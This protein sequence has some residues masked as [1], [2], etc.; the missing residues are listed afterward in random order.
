MRESNCLLCGFKAE[1]LFQHHTHIY[2][3]SL[4]GEYAFESAHLQQVSHLTDFQRVNLLS[5]TSELSSQNRPVFFDFLE[6]NEKFHNFINVNPAEIINE[7]IYHSQKLD[8]LLQEIGRIARNS[9]VGARINLNAKLFAK[10][11]FNGKDEIDNLMMN[12]GHKYFDDVN[13]EKYGPGFY[14]KLPN[15]S[16]ILSHEG[17]QKI[18]E[19]SHGINSR[20]V[21]I[22]I[23]F[24]PQTKDNKCSAIRKACSPWFEASTVDAKPHNNFINTEII[25]RINES[26][27]VVADFTENNTGV[28]FE[29]GYARGRQIPCIHT[30]REDALPNLHFDVKAI[31]FETW[32]DYDEL[33]KKIRNHILAFEWHL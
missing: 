5:K 25:A 21:F 22:A 8:S 6:R 2:K 18:E 26:R 24:D 20:D 17:W 16:V 4:C 9:L 31:P 30:V 3:C 12:V 28:Y 32:K 1:Y 27:F 33:E 11:K 14:H 15:A 10:L 13:I 23:S 19:M 29:A 7:P